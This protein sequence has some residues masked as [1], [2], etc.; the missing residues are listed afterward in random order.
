MIAFCKE[1]GIVV[2]AYAPFGRPGGK[3]FYMRHDVPPLLQDSKLQEI[4]TKHGKTV[5]QVILRYLVSTSNKSLY[6]TGFMVK[7]KSNVCKRFLNSPNSF[8]F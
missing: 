8:Q 5:A 4:A 2:T 6:S 3:V 1:R 7:E